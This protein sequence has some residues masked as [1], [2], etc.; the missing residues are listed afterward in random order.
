MMISMMMKTMERSTRDNMSSKTMRI[1][2]GIDGWLKVQ[3]NEKQ[4][5]KR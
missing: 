1:K 5:E 2:N 4:E 3:I